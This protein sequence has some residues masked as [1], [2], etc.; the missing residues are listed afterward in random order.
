MNLKRSYWIAFAA[1]T[2]ALSVVI[3]AMAPDF[4]PAPLYQRLTSELA[5]PPPPGFHEGGNLVLEFE[6]PAEDV[7]HLHWHGMIYHELHEMQF[8]VTNLTRGEVL[9]ER[10]I[11]DEKLW[12]WKGNNEAGD[13]LRVE[14]LWL[15]DT[16]PSFPA[17][18]ELADKKNP[19]ST[20]STIA[21]EGWP[22]EWQ[23]DE[24]YAAKFVVPD[25]GYSQIEL[26]GITEDPKTR[27]RV[28]LYDLTQDKSLK[29]FT[30]RG[31]ADESGPRTF[32]AGNEAG[33]ELELRL[34]WQRVPPPSLHSSGSPPRLSMTVYADGQPTEFF[35]L[36]GL[37]YEWP[38]RRLLWL[39]IPTLLLSG[40]VVLG[41]SLGWKFASSRM[42]GITLV[43]V[44]LMAAI[45]SCLSWQQAVSTET[46]HLDPD[47][48]GRYGRQMVEWLTT[49]DDD[50]KAEV[51]ESMD[52]WRY[53]W[54]PMTPTLVGLL[55]LC[56]VAFHPAYVLVSALASFGTVLLFHRMLRKN[57][58]LGELSAFAGTVLL[59]SHHF[60]LKSFAKPSTDPVGLLLV[61]SGLCLV[62]DRLC[63]RKSESGAGPGRTVA[64]A[65]VIFLLIV[66]RPPGFLMAGFFIGAAVLADAWS[67][68]KFRM[69]VALSEGV[70]LGIGP[71][72]LFAALFFGFDWWDN[73]Q[74]A[75]SSSTG[76]H[77]VSTA[78]RFSMMMLSMLQLL[79]LFWLGMRRQDWRRPEIWLLG[80]WAL[81]YLA[82]IIGVRA[83]FVTR[84]FLPMLPVP[85]ALAA[86]GLDRLC[87]RGGWRRAFGVALALLTVLMNIAVVVYHTILPSIPPEVIAEWIYH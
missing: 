8:K 4:R 69:G 40:A 9:T 17:S 52:V 25:G 64:L 62:A 50:R 13:R 59:I 54:L 6:A 77:H 73:F 3:A 56:G 57:F 66:A 37:E 68:Q 5:I 34:R 61:M 43:I 82:M 79:P 63:R 12:G 30:I 36:L 45:A 70:R 22:D 47:G 1:F 67:R 29:K 10:V 84:M 39:W 32:K 87:C 46:T 23:P 71:A 75:M 72:V 19:D 74:T 60:F 38:T 26:K 48:F 58:G 86:I 83:G 11:N 41:Q 81:F 24:V 31:V 44:S 65:G 14:L 85:I 27:V 16:P 21:L 51:V 28:E 15:R 35:P 20:R 42:V 53:S 78:R 49:D 18:I 7:N 76:F 55:V 2:A 80:L 33:D